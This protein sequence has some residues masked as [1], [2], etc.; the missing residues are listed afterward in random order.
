M[1]FGSNA[2]PYLHLLESG[3]VRVR[4]CKSQNLLGFLLVAIMPLYLKLV[5][6]HVLYKRIFSGLL[7]FDRHRFGSKRVEIRGFK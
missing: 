2:L 6:W 1:L 4:S 7:A 5:S 3:P